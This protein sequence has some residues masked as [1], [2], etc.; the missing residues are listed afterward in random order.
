MTRIGLA[1]GYDS[2]Q[3]IRDFTD[4]MRGADERGFE[5]GFFSETLALMRDSVTAMTSF[6]LA[7]T[8]VKLGCTQIVG[9]RSPVLMAQTLATLDELSGGRM[10]LCP[11]AATA[12]HAR[13]HGFAP[14][15]AVQTLRE[16]VEALRLVMSGEKVS[17]EGQFV[18]LYDTQMGWRPVRPHVPLWFAA[19]SAT[20]LRLAGQLGDGVLLNTV[21]SPEYA[22]NAIRIVREAVEGAGRD[23]ST[24]EVAALI[25]TSIED[26]RDAAIDAVRWEVAYK[27]LP[28]KFRTQAGPRM[29]VGE[30]HIDP[31]E[32]PRLEAAHKAGGK[33]ALEKA[34][35]KET[36]AALTAS[37]TA[38]EVKERIQRYRDAGVKL[39][40][41]RPAARHQTQ[42]ILD[43]FAPS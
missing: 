10:I 28:H 31:A 43:L 6:A 41:L 11:G 13:T 22:A 23:W 18:K 42:R 21:S 30:P 27:F 9:L 33:R 37:G 4:G 32:L 16:W 26:D 20:G 3:G 38:D 12:N 17:Y 1:C 19:T 24:F 35:A 25:N 5:I 29:R 39:P 2:T 15:D 40:I 7:T 14:A 36:V 34:L 8:K